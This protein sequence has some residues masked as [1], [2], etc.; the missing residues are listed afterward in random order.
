[1]LLT[2]VR[3]AHAEW[4]GYSGRDFDRPLTPKGMKDALATARAI[5][6]AGLLP[7]V[8]LASPARRTRDTATVLARELELAADALHFEDG[9]YNA[10]AA[11]LEAAARKAAAQGDHVL[12][13]AHNPGISE[14]ARQLS[15]DPESKPLKPAGWVTGRLL[16][17][18][19]LPVAM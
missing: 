2:L 7:A 10:S 3:H 14:F 13:V 18:D 5:R 6:S 17:A 16:P 9:L 8:L 12:V 15:G 4:P 11:A 1:L 19:H